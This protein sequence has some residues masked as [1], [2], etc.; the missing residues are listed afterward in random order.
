MES[1]LKRRSIRKFNEKKVTK[2]EI[3][4]ILKAGMQ[5]PSAYNAQPWSFIVTNKIIDKEAIA[6]ASPY[7]KCIKDAAY[8]IVIYCDLEKVKN[9]DSWWPQDLSAATQNILLAIAEKEMAGVWLGMYPDEN[10]VAALKKHF[11][12]EKNQVPF[13]VVALGYSNQKNEKVDRYDDNKITWRMKEGDR[14]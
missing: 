12:L 4:D 3:K 5:A 9:D 6:Q 11:D 10:R 2:D 13:A 7:A 1:I 8:G 14:K